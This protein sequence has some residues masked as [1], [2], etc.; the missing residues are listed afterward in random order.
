MSKLGV[1]LV[2]Y[3]GI[4]Y[5]EACINSICA[6]DWKGE[7][8]VFCVDN[9]SQ[10][11]SPS[12]LQ[13][14]YGDKEWFRLIRLGK[15]TGFSAANNA[16]LHEAVEAGCNLLMILNNDTCIEKDMIRKLVAWVEGKDCICGPAP[17]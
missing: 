16:G 8:L 5:N 10:D 17:V 3:N 11:A 4:E 9:N 13:E 1:V 7:I 6:G 15:N 14:R 2:N 12:R